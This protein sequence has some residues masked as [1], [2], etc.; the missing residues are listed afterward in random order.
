M[1]QSGGEFGLGPEKGEGLPGEFGVNY[2]FIN[3][4]RLVSV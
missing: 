2:A 1:K 4:V 3:Q